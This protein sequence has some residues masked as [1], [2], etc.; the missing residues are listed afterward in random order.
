MSNPNDPAY[1]TGRQELGYQYDP[2]KSTSVAQTYI[3]PQGGMTIR[4]RFVMAA[5]GKLAAK[6]TEYERTDSGT[7]VCPEDFE[8]RSKEVAKIACLY[9]DAAL[10]EEARTRSKA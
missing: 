9:A 6:F 8:T 5:M 3:V 4:Q 1:P 2:S 10:A 7:R